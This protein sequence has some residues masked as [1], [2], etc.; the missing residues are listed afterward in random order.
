VKKIVLR[1]MLLRSKF[2]LIDL[3]L[4]VDFKSRDVDN[5]DILQSKELI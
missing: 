1:F 4:L 5:G 2:I 3:G